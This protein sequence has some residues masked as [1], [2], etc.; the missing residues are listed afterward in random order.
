[1]IP[2]IGTS[3]LRS[4]YAA[5]TSLAA[6]SMLAG[7]VVSIRTVS[8]P[9]CSA[10]IRA[11]SSARRPPTMTVLPRA[12]SST[13]RARPMPLVAPGMKTVFPLMFMVSACG[14]RDAGCR[15][16]LSGDRRSL[17]RAGT[18]RR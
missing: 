1:M 6:A 9:G 3:T 13:A 2:A 18:G 14:L 7:S 5:S 4:G 8:M 10:A 12:R 17:V 11:S 16:R 15:D